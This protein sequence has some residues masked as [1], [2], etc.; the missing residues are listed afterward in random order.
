MRRLSG[1]LALGLLA[2]CSA[3][4][5]DYEAP[6]A[7]EVTAELFAGDGEKV[8]SLALW[9][10]NF[11]D[12]V[13]TQLVEQ[14]LASAPTVEAALARLRAARASREQS[15]ASYYPQFTANGSYVWSRGWGAGETGEWNK[16]LGASADA[17]W[18]LDIFGGVRRSVE[19]AAAAEARLAY[20]LQETRVS[21][22]AEIASAYVAV[23]RCKVQLT[24]AEQNLT[25]Q[26][27]NAHLVRQ[28]YETG[29]ITRYDVVT[30]EAQVA[31]TKAQLPQ[32]RE[33]LIAAQL[34][35]D[36][37]TGQAPYATKAL[38]DSTQQV[39]T[40][41]ALS[42]KVLPN[43]LLRRRADIRI[44]EE[45]IHGQTAAV[46]VAT[47][48]LYPRFSLGGSVGLSSPD[49]SPWSSYSRTV[50]FGP[51]VRWNIFGFGTWRKQIAAAQ[52]TLDATLADYRNTVLQAYQEAETAWNACAIEAQRTDALVV[53]E[54][55][56]EEALRIANKLYELGE[57]DI[58]DVLS[59]QANLLSAQE[60]LVA[61]RADLF[62]NMIT[63]YRALGG[64]WSDAANAAVLIPL[65]S[66]TGE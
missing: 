50:N 13:L 2:G 20:T 49:L 54:A 5:P 10:R 30:A 47:A 36:W 16:R 65:D 40:L 23:R 26:E 15:E 61:H 17:S 29:D 52:A 59:Q 1:I 53:A 14:G 58:D 46:G 66:E 60:T 12:P 22:A 8:T 31:R 6:T 19:Q 41:P 28:R 56:C 3:V 32:Y 64:G 21:L 35:L 51:S 27:R 11:Q 33:N 63:L 38:L 39:M 43:E 42:P 7:P 37:L 48:D 34:K 25:L 9:W 44:A 62:D 45:T 4:G 18:E 55:H 57:K 24:I